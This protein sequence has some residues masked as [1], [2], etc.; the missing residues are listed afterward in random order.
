MGLFFLGWGAENHR[1]K[2][3]WLKK[4]KK[5]LTLSR[6]LLSS[7]EN[8]FGIE[9]IWVN[10]VILVG[11]ELIKSFA[12]I[13]LISSNLAFNICRIDFFIVFVP[14]WVVSKIS[15]TS[16]FPIHKYLFY[17]SCKAAMKIALNPLLFQ[18]FSLNSSLDNTSYTTILA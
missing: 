9:P 6:S 2:V 7:N 15:Q 13:I 16:F 8:N 5:F 11:I 10:Y 17:S 4:K 1:F 18:L 14:S 12:P 3:N